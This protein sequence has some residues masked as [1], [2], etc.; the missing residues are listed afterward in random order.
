MGSNWIKKYFLFYIHSIGLHNI[1]VSIKIKW[2]GTP[3]YYN[4]IYRYSV[5]TK[6]NL[7]AKNYYNFMKLL[8][9][10]VNGIISPPYIG[11]YIIY[12]RRWLYYYSYTVL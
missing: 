12:R 5:K 8:S 10:I 2:I 4:I 3:I 11:T 7:L 6:I 1:E 9:K